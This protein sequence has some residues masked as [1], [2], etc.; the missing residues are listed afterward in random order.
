MRAAA[1]PVLTACLLCLN[2][3][4]AENFVTV[5]AWADPQYASEKAGNGKTRKESYI[6]AKGEYFEGTCR[7][8]SIEKASFDGIV[9][10]LSK[11][12][13]RQQYYPARNAASADQ[14]IVVH[15]GMTIPYVNE[16]EQQAIENP[17]SYDPHLA[18]FAV[19]GQTMDTASSAVASQAGSQQSVE[20]DIFNGQQQGAINLAMDIDKM[21]HT[22][23]A[24]SAA[25]LL[26]YTSQLAR[27]GQ[28]L[29]PTEVARTL[30][31]NLHEDRYFVIIQAWDF[32]KLSHD[33]KKKL[34]WTARMSMRAPGMN[35]RLALPRMGRV[36]SDYFGKSNDQ[37]VTAEFQPA[38]EGRVDI[39]PVRILGEV[40]SAQLNK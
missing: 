37:V 14:I 8:P 22:M 25:G 21:A 6:I 9:Q 40:S 27:E 11:S 17:T 1:F 15:W 35:F 19:A 7:D 28:K 13:A 20:R 39:G 18:D 34:L 4:S 36:A 32:Q 16:Y 31:A 38:R 33:H 24:N 10:L 12:L 3:A 30:M 26:G 29:M 2:Q 5:R 23:S